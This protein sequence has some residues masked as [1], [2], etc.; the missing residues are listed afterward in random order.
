[1][2]ILIQPYGGKVD[3]VVATRFRTLEVFKVIAELFRD[4]ESHIKFCTKVDGFYEN[5]KKV[6]ITMTIEMTSSTFLDPRDIVTVRTA[7][8]K[9]HYRVEQIAA[10][11]GKEYYPRHTSKA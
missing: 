5:D 3:R 1:M 4:R 2:N 8:G 6:V 7:E 9:E 11:F 10:L